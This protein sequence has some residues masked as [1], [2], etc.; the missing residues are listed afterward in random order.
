M[1]LL[2][3]RPLVSLFV[4]THP[5]YRVVPATATQDEAQADDVHLAVGEPCK[6]AAYSFLYSY[7]ALPYMDLSPTVLLHFRL[8]RLCLTPVITLYPHTTVLLIDLLCVPF[9]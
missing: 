1:L 9:D 4:I 5:A 7:S 8:R 2:T 3:H 6:P